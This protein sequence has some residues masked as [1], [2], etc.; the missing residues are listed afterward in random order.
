M[1]SCLFHT[2]SR[3]GRAL[4][5][6]VLI[7]VSQLSICVAAETP[8]PAVA[9]IIVP[10][11]D[12]ISFGSGTLVDVRDEYGLVVTNWH[13]V[14]DASDVVSVVFPDGFRS[15]A[16]IRKVDDDWDLAVLVIWRPKAEPVPLAKQAPRPGDALTIAGYGTGTYRTARG[17]CTQYVAPGANFPFEMVEVSVQARQGDSGGPIFNRQGELAGVLFGAGRGTT[18]GSYVGRVEWFLASVVPDLPRRNSQI[19]NSDLQPS[20]QTTSKTAAVHKPIEDDGVGRSPVIAK[21]IPRLSPQDDTEPPTVSS[22]SPRRETEAIITW[23]DLAGETPFQQ[24][25]SVLAM[26]GVLAVSITLMRWLGS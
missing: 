18:S 8:H 4:W 2:R 16:T 14:R 25:K 5:L 24:A 23:N 19:A 3:C 1:T 6:T 22:L 21:R 17:R 12:G 20:R 15:T 9:R 10:E 26:I 7:T 13:V 11:R